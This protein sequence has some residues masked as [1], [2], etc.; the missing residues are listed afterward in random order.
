MEQFLSLVGMQAM[1]LAVRSGIVLTSSY[2]LKQYSQ[3]LTTVGDE[4]LYEELKTLQN[5]LDSKIQI[6]TPA[7]NLI[8]LRS[9]EGNSALESASALTGSMQKDIAL[10]GHKIASVTTLQ[11]NQ[12]TIRH[13][14]TDIRALIG[15]INGSIPLLQLAISASGE[16]LSTGLPDSVSPSRMLQASAFL[17]IAD[18]QFTAKPQT[19]VQVGPDFVV[20]IY[21]VF[22]GYSYEISAKAS[23]H[24]SSQS[25]DFDSI[26]KPTWQEVLHKARLRLYRTPCLPSQELQSGPQD[27][28][29]YSYHLEITEDRDDGRL[30][31]IPESPEESSQTDLIPISKITKIL[32]TNSAAILNIKDDLEAN[33]TPILLLKR[34]LDTTNLRKARKFST[35]DDETQ[36][37][38]DC[39]LVSEWEDIAPPQPRTNESNRAPPHSSQ[40][41]SYLDPKWIALEIYTADASDDSE[42]DQSDS[43]SIQVGS[44]DSEQ[45]TGNELVTDDMLGKLSSLCLD[46]DCSQHSEE[47]T[48]LQYTAASIS[49]SE[50][51]NLFSM[52]TT[53]LSLL[54]L[55]IR[56]AA[57]QETQQQSHLSVPDHVLTCFLHSAVQPN[58]AWN[59]K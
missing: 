42:L 12:T 52:V 51:S 11:A 44:E 7:I 38:V 3:F 59:K 41:P 24:N 45:V 30:H 25:L 49:R 56:L 37:H 27:L 33:S 29:A 28:S 17:M 26:S 1:K 55:V 31:D 35:P 16:S 47:A 53:S 19:T 5:D 8:E 15:R 9:G 40:F 6:I 43:E 22:K 20:S 54:E 21:M 18:S 46:Q 34:E 2:A 50:P 48:P 10:L 23:G 14:I 32:Y 36:H 4:E 58:E 57:L 13:L 39:Q